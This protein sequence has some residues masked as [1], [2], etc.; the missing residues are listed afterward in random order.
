MQQICCVAKKIE[1]IYDLR[2]HTLNSKATHPCTLI[3]S[4][5]LKME[6]IVGYRISLCRIPVDRESHYNSVIPGNMIS[7]FGMLTSFNS[8]LN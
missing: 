8:H 4:K 6:A 5:L 3:K 1:M 2:I 7:N